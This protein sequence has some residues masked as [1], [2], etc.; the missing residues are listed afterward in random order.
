[1]GEKNIGEN[2][3][4]K[5]KEVI[6][7]RYRVDY[8]KLEKESEE[9]EIESKIEKFLKYLK[10]GLLMGVGYGLM[11]G[12]MWGIKGLVVGPIMGAIVGTGLS[13]IFTLYD[14]NLWERK[15]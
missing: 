10:M 12:W 8:I 14:K 11:F 7:N 13:L 5:D 15:E 6:K 4:I 1:M 3:K 9:K 2:S